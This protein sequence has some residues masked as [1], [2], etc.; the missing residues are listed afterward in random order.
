[1]EDCNLPFNKAHFTAEGYMRAC[2]N[3]YENF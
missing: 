1:M 3:D 2:C